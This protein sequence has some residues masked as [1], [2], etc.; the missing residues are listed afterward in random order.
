MVNLVR[1]F[2]LSPKPLDFVL[3]C[4]TGSFI[5][6][7]KCG[8]SIFYHDYNW[9]RSC[10]RLKQEHIHARCSNCGY[11]FGTPAKDN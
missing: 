10:S 6:C 8:K 4:W 2:G 9:H 1:L 3:N 11:T 7:P 5:R